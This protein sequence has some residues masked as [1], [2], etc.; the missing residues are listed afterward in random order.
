MADVL[1]DLSAYRLDRAA[2]APEIAWQRSLLYCQDCGRLSN[3]ALMVCPRCGGEALEQ[4]S[5]AGEI[6][7]YTTASSS[8]GDV[9]LALVQLCDGPLLM[10]R[11]SGTDRKLRIGM[12]V[13]F[14]PS[15]LSDT[16]SC[17]SV[18]CPLES[19]PIGAK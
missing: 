11:I 15:A 4:V 18:F 5:H 14:A 7:S 6:Y 13:E 1:N 17:G 10:A 12:R 2:G 16:A 8:R 3:E 19:H 9:R